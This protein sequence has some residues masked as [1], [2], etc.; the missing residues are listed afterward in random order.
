MNDA[1]RKKVQEAMTLLEKA[2]EIIDTCQTEENEAFE[3]LSE[4]LQAGEKGQAMEANAETL[5]QAYDN[6]GSV[7]EDLGN[8]E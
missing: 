2:Q 8:I 1:R 5:S 3:N 7:L 4:N 6:I